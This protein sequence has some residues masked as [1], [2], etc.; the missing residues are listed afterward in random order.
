MSI[1]WVFSY[2]GYYLRHTCALWSSPSVM[3]S[4]SCNFL[5]TIMLCV[6]CSKSL[7]FLQEYMDN[8]L[9][10]NEVLH[11]IVWSGVKS[12]QYDFST[13]A[14][15]WEE[16]LWLVHVVV[17]LCISGFYLLESVIRFC[18]QCCFFKATNSLILCHLGFVI[19]LRI[20]SDFSPLFF[21]QA[22]HWVCFLYRSQVADTSFLTQ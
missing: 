20:H 4:V 7:K 22:Y 9:D 5:I 18:G 14:T 16:L 17:V 11:I 1:V 3:T 8:K 2:L 13:M 6:C 12:T 10:W 19:L 21:H 15:G